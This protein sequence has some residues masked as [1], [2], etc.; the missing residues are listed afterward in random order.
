MYEKLIL[1]FLF[2]KQTKKN[3][4]A[5]IHECEHDMNLSIHKFLD[6]HL[7]AFIK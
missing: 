4:L 5:E 7:W 1:N 2:E 3:Y 6:R